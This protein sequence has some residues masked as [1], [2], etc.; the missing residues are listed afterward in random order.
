[1]KNVLIVDDEKQ[2]LL[3]LE[4]GL[5]P[6]SK[7][8]RVL[9]A[10]DGKEAVDVLNSEKVDLVVTDLKMP[11][12]DGFALLAFMCMHHPKVPFIVMTA[13]GTP[14]IEDRIRNLGSVQYL[15]KPLDISTLAE[16][17][18]DALATGSKGYLSGITLPTFL[19]L[20][21][22][23]K[24][25]ATLTIKSEDRV[26]HIYFIK[27][28]MRNAETGSL[29]GEE[30]AFEIIGWEDTE[31]EIDN[32]CKKK[33]KLIK[34]PL[35]NILMEAC[36]LKDENDRGSY[37]KGTQS[38]KGANIPVGDE[39]LLIFE[40]EDKEAPGQEHLDIGGATTTAESTNDKKSTNVVNSTDSKEVNAMAVQDK[41]QEFSSLEGF[42]GVGVF[43]PSGESLAMM[44]G[45]NKANLKE[46]GVL[47]NNVLM[48]AQRASLDMGTGRGQL[49]HVE[50][51]HAHIIVRCLNEGTD[52]LKSQ[53]G[54]AHLHLVLILTNENSI[55]MAKMK[56]AKII[57]SLADDFRI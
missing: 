52:P 16:A 9:T 39:D 56:I 49:V 50:A 11:R 28:E 40:E 8:F 5:K 7:L 1:M 46:I 24:K 23:E 21:G 36:R 22:M 38:A 4:D 41:L 33:K 10:G 48:N 53:P 19:Q 14:A 32:G 43:T 31:I 55:G 35:A 42:A 2:F 17:I 26:G 47:A 15:E 51:E 18:K 6:H 45:N 12:M 27:G 34:E 3:S 54:K 20:F 29:E 44:E 57:T 25:T 13:F 37:G 30:A